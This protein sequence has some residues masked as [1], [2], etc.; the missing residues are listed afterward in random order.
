MIKFYINRELSEKLDIRLSKWKRWSREFLPPDPLGGLQ[1]GYARQYTMDQAFVV[2]LGGHLVAD[3]HF[4]IPEAKQIIQELGPWIKRHRPARS[5][6]KDEQGVED[7][8]VYI[9][10]RLSSAS[11]GVACAYL[12]RKRLSDEPYGQGRPDA[13]HEVYIEKPIP[14]A[15]RYNDLE[16]VDTLDKMDSRILY[17]TRLYE[18]FMNKMAARQV[19][20]MA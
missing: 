13:R 9:F 16:Q 17:V 5:G 18:R 11:E 4:S 14:V 8:R 20:R 7:V 2:F 15:A 12:G 1:S 3:L 19:S 10:R 6:K